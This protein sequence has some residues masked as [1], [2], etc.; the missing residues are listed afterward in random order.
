M[1][2]DKD[3]NDYLDAFRPKMSFPGDPIT[4][5]KELSDFDIGQIHAGLMIPSPASIKSM[6]R[7]IRKWRGIPNPDLI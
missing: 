2:D 4:P 3:Q 1:S 7:E 5:P 6:A